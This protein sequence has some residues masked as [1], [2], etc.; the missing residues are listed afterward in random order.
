L[1]TD[2]FDRIRGV[3][4]TDA[5]REGKKVIRGKWIFRDRP[6]WIAVT[7]PA[8][9]SRELFDKVQEQLRH[10]DARYC[11]PV[12]PRRYEWWCMSAFSG[13]GRA[14]LH[15]LVGNGQHRTIAAQQTPVLRHP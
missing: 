14:A 9:V 10:H 6:N 4:A 12:T 7:V 2:R 3:H 13:C 11:Q 8:I 5:N 1:K 15:A